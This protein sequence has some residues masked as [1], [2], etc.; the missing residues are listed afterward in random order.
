MAELRRE[1]GEVRWTW[2]A[3]QVRIRAR[4]DEG[5]LVLTFA[6]PREQ[7]LPWF[8]LPATLSHLSL[9]LGEGSRF[10]TA[11]AYWR[12]YLAGEVGSADTNGDLK[13]PLWSAD[14]GGPVFTWILETP[15][16]NEV[17]FTDG[18]GRLQMR[19]GH[20]FDRFNQETPF[21]VRLHVGT[22][23]LSGA[24]RYRE[25][26]K[27]QGEW[28]SLE[29]KLARVPD[30]R[31]LIGATHV[32]L[33]GEQVLDRAD[34]RDW[35][36]LL[37]WLRSED[38]AAWRR[39]FGPELRAALEADPPG[40]WQQR[41][42]V[43]A[44]QEALG[45][46]APPAASPEDPDLI[47][48][49]AE[50]ARRMR[51][52]AEERLGAWMAPSAQWGQGLSRPVLDQLR[53][54]G[55]VRL[56]I[57]I[58]SWTTLFQQP[59]AVALARQLGYLVAAYDSYDTA[60]A[61]GVNDDWLTAQMPRALAERCA[62]FRADGTPQPGFG[63]KGSYLN[64]GCAL[65]YAQERMRQI[66]RE[67]G[68]NSLFLDVD[69]T[70]MARDDHNPQH[71]DGA[72][73]MVAARRRRLQWVS[74]ELALPLGSED[75]NAVTSRPLLFAHGLQTWGFG[76][77]D[78]QMRRDERSPYYLGR[79]WPPEEPGLFFKPA[80]VK[81]LYRRTVFNPRDRLP[82]YQAVFHDALINSHHWQTDSLKFSDVAETRAL[83]NLL[84]N[85]PPLFNLSRATL[86]ARLPAMR[87][88][89]AAFRPLHEAL[90]NQALVD[91]RW[92]DAAGLVQ[93]TRFGD[94][95][96]ITANFGA[97]AFPVEGTPLAGRSARA[98]LADGREISFAAR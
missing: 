93:E 34:V 3:A 27:A 71:P 41:E 22:G 18:P 32:Y 36:G 14:R 65:P 63:G 19:A 56:W 17:R 88:I 43:A 77:T 94:G 81:A 95:S 83:L 7:T 30:G 10:A 26:L 76:W 61:P 42:I 2:P 15:F 89:D 62:I 67:S 44:L 49:Q 64:P 60:V 82:L 50:R 74:D 23:W 97:E 57:G 80:S 48:K 66:V 58:P 8:S 92:R 16:A 84:Y 96:R 79:W 86:A 75:G 52:L 78:T 25:W 29:S 70:A 11:D 68:G 55:L 47:A 35:P 40:A 85:T 72:E 1:G 21:Q 98:R 45:A 24:L 12:R 6:T 91:F 9:A 46:Q 28:A 73:A 38:A 13:L 5:D 87:R 4:L 39:G 31:K 20:R 90:W 54:A 51:R 69:G 59:E 37:R 33:W 53:D